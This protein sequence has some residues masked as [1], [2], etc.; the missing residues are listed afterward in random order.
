MGFVEH[1]WRDKG[2]RVLELNHCFAT[3]LPA[4]AEV[5]SLEEGLS[6]HW[7][8][9][10]ELTRARL[11]PPTLVSLITRYAAGNRQVWAEPNATAPLTDLTTSADGR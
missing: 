10:A 6:F 1:A 7:V 8:P 4:K 2:V 3:R 11:Q 5:V 9:L